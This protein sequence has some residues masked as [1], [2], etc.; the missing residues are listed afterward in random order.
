MTS[1]WKSLFGSCLI[2]TM[3]SLLSYCLG[4]GNGNTTADSQLR[5]VFQDFTFVG[6]VA[7]STESNLQTMAPPHP[8]T[9]TAIPEPLLDGRQYIFHHRRPVDDE[10]LALVLLPSKFKAEDL[11]VISGP[12][13]P[14]DLVSLVYGGPLFKFRLGASGRNAIIFN[15]PCPALTSA[16]QGGGDWVEEDYVLAIPP[17]H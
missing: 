11:E 9:G 8:S 5:G 15:R 4:C 2:V 14:G 17:K 12:N 10:R 7:Y 16:E 3:T 13:T 1:T 6:A